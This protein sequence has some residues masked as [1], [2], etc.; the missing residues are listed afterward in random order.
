MKNKGFTLV[1][2]I[3]V[4]ILLGILATAAAPRFI[5]VSRDAKITALQGLEAQFIMTIDLIRAKARIEGLRPADRN[6]GGT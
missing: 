2:L 5:D 6:P 4:I 3:T 1:E